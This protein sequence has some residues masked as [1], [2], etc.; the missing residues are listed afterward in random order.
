MP[1]RERQTQ[2]KYAATAAKTLFVTPFSQVAPIVR[3]L[4]LFSEGEQLR[5][6][7]FLITAALSPSLVW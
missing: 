2:Y 4:A 7:E 1:H 5:V 6:K 3:F